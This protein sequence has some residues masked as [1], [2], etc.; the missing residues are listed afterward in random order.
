MVQ[1]T[2]LCQSVKFCLLFS[3]LNLKLRVGK[4]QPGRDE[5]V[6]EDRKTAPALRA[7][8]LR[9]YVPLR[10]VRTKVCP[11]ALPHPVP[12]EVIFTCK[13]KFI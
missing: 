5:G 13:F 10:C 12:A 1:N 8:P 9:S 2:F 4:T 6:M 11:P 3:C 7:R